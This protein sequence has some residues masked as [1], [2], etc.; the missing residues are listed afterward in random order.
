MTAFARAVAA[1]HRDPNLSVACTW[2]PGW[3]RAW[4][5]GLALD[6]EAGTAVLSVETVGVRIIDSAP[7]EGGF[8][9]SQPGAI[10]G[11]RNV[12]AA[13][14]DVPGTVMRGDMLTA[15]ADDLLVETAEMDPEGV[16]WRL[17][18]SVAA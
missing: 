3:D 11:R 15:G 17:M 14:S 12:D 1:L 5:R 18:L 8:G 10:A 16:T 2:A 7:I 4:P 13:V 6:L 9:T